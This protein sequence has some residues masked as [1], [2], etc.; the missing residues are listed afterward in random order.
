MRQATIMRKT[1]ETDISIQ[2]ELDGR[3]AA[4][5][6]TGVGFLDHML[7]LFARHGGFDLTVSAKRRFAAKQYSFS[8]AARRD[9]SHVFRL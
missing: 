9:T 6:E 5:I 8:L 4:K 7:T 2:L 1:A 3:G